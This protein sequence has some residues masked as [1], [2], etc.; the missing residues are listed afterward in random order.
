M[1]KKEKYNIPDKD[2][3]V[4]KS[5]L[6]M[7]AEASEKRGYEIPKNRKEWVEYIRQII[8]TEADKM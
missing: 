4:P 7:L 8:D 3:V 6:I 2:I 5:D 1:T